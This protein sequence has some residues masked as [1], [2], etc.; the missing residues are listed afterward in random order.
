MVPPAPFERPRRTLRSEERIGLQALLLIAGLLPWILAL[1][2]VRA[3]PIA[4][5][6]QALCHQRPE[7]TLELL[8]EPMLVCSRCAGLYAGVALG[9][10]LPLPRRWLPRGRALVLGALAVTVVDVVTQ[11]L[12]LHPPLHLVRLATGLLLGWS[13]SGFMFS[14]LRSEA[15][16]SAARP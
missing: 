2:R 5:V 1:A 6:F 12:G 7:R 9:A 13:S 14:A 10:L 16:T 11:D 15:A 4:L 8:G 3:Q